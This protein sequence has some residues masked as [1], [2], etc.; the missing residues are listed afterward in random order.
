MASF[1]V[2][3]KGVNIWWIVLMVTLDALLLICISLALTMPSILQPQT[4]HLSPGTFSRSYIWV[5]WYI[6]WFPQRHE[7]IIITYWIDSAF[8]V[9]TT[10]LY[11]ILPLTL[12]TT[13]GHIWDSKH[14]FPFIQMTKLENKEASAWPESPVLELGFNIIY[15][16][17]KPVAHVFHTTF[18]QWANKAYSSYQF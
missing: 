12:I 3:G 9:Y 17:T 14:W 10:F 2:P 4:A 6:A 5:N 8:I 15:F 1:H 7:S 11:K 16:H 13:Q 18:T